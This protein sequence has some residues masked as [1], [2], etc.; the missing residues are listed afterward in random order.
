MATNLNGF[1][2]ENSPV[3]WSQLYSLYLEFNENLLCNFT[4]TY[5]VDRH[6][7]FILEIGVFVKNFTLS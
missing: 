4:S 2:F 7:N 5:S 6:P 1:H 3:E